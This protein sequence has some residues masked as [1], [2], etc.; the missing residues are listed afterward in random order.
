ML[1]KQTNVNKRYNYGGIVEYSVAERNM[2][3]AAECSH[4]LTEVVERL[5]NWYIHIGRRLF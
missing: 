1:R 3:C 5:T 2:R 4:G